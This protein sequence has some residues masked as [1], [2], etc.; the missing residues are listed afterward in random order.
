MFFEPQ[1]HYGG[2]SRGTPLQNILFWKTTL[3]DFLG[4]HLREE[5][6]KREAET[7]RT[8]S[9]RAPCPSDHTVDPSSCEASLPVVWEERRETDLGV[10]PPIRS[11]E[12]M[13]TVFCFDLSVSSSFES[14]KFDATETET[15]AVRDS[16]TD[17][18]SSSPLPCKTSESPLAVPPHSEPEETPEI[19]KTPVESCGLSLSP[20][21]VP[22]SEGAG[23]DEEATA[24]SRRE[25][26]FLMREGRRRDLLVF[27]GLA[28]PV[29]ASAGFGFV[30]IIPVPPFALFLSLL[31]VYLLV[32]VCL[33][34][35]LWRGR[36]SKGGEFVRD[37]EKG[38]GVREEMEWWQQG[39]KELQLLPA[40][41][42]RVWVCAVPFFL[43]ALLLI[44]WAVSVPSP[45]RGHLEEYLRYD[46][47]LAFVSLRS[48][49][50]DPSS[51]RTSQS[52]TSCTA[53]QG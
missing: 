45:L 21:A 5:E 34:A 30:Q 40:W 8:V 46:L 51:H 16:H 1:P 49:S 25:F 38:L 17:R 27:G 19:E 42:R 6:W 23:D 3:E 18:P 11:P 44:C 36:K 20:L 2:C 43:C 50:V 7:P 24:K 26:E 12:R 39:V 48:V 41:E 47:T 28:A 53:A 22:Q 37:L 4:N 29:L 32:S 31:S 15:A 13:E 10:G 52:E 33:W 14:V 9:E 35:A